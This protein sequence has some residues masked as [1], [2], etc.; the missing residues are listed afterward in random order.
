MAVGSTL[1]RVGK[2]YVRHI[3]QLDK[4]EMLWTKDG[5]SL[6]VS[7]RRKEE[8]L[9]L[10]IRKDKQGQLRYCLKQRVPIAVGCLQGVP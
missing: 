7:R 1:K 5:K 6:P 2:R 4:E 3:V 10:I 8:V 9:R